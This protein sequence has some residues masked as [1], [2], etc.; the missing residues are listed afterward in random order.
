[1]AHRLLEM[2]K[3]GPLTRSPGGAGSPEM[4][5]ALSPRAIVHVARVIFYQHSLMRARAVRRQ[6]RPQLN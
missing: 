4:L 1:M 2:H 3:F 6:F 5:I